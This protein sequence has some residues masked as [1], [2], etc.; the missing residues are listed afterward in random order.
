[1]SDPRSRRPTP[2][3][4]PTLSTVVPLDDAARAELEA[5]L[6]AVPA[7]LEPLGVDTL[8]GFLCGVIVQPQ[9]PTPAQWLAHATDGEG[10]PLPVGFD[11]GRLHELVRRRH[12]ELAGAIAGRAWFDPWIFEGEEI[13]P[14][15]E[16]AGDADLAADFGAGVDSISAALYPWVAGFAAALELFPGLLR[17]GDD[18]L[19]EP[20]ALLYRHLDADDLEDADALLALIEAS[21]PPADLAEAVRDL[22]AGVLQLADVA[23]S[24]AASTPSRVPRPAAD[25]RPG[26]GRRPRRVPAAQLARHRLRS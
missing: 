9:P 19:L 18:A 17:A 23:A 1:M 11:A 3:T 5:L 7:P 20:L 12:A 10:R 14:G 16:G 8:D 24:R 15:E 13:E 22:V 25:R 6:D 4:S 26:R 21:E 2:P